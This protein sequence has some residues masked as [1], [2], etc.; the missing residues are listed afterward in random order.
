M[1]VILYNLRRAGGMILDAILPRSERRVRAEALGTD[2]LPINPTVH[3]LMG[4]EIITL[5]PYEDLRDPIQSLKYDR[6]VHSAHLLSD[7][8]A[9]YLREDIASRK[10]FSSKPVLLVPV[11]LDAK[12]KRDRGY[13]QISLVTDALPDEFKDGTLARIAGP[14]LERI[15][16]TRAQTKLPRNERL[17][18][19]AGAFAVSDPELI[20]GTHV[21]LIDDVATTGATLVNAC[22]PLERAGAE[23]TLVALAR[24]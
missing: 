7:A 22:I 9:E 5:A 12:R 21:Y 2:D 18:N 6:S 24:A 23:V 10:L 11:P 17:S 20:H 13:N 14:L 19:V 8:L 16:A 1:D 15:R 4:R 3:S